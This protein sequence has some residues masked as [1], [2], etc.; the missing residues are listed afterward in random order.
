MPESTL[1]AYFL[2]RGSTSGATSISA[3]VGR[4]STHAGRLRIGLMM[5][6]V[7]SLGIAAYLGDPTGFV[8]D[9]P[10][11]RLLRGM[12]LIKGLMAIAA[13]AAVWW[14]FGQPVLKPVAAGYLMGS[15]ALVG[16]TMLIWQLTWIPAAAILF[17]A[18]GLSML[19]VSW[20]A[21]GNCAL[22]FPSGLPLTPRHGNRPQKSVRFGA[23]SP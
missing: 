1:R 11:A 12:A 23:K 9:P 2:H 20:R 17:H 21:D 16:S 3:A 15:W 19:I 8:S 14:R 4:R 13:I 18:A 7:V 10:L 22:R 5:G 6:C